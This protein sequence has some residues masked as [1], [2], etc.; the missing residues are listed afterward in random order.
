MWSDD[1]FR[2]AVAAETA[3]PPK[4]YDWAQWDWERISQYAL[5]NITPARVPGQV[6][7]YAKPPLGEGK[8]ACKRFTEIRLGQFG[9]EPENI[10]PAGKKR[11]APANTPETPSKPP[12]KTRVAGPRKPRARG[13]RKTVGTK[14]LPKSKEFVEP[15][16]SGS[17]DGHEEGDEDLSQQPKIWA[18]ESLRQ[19]RS[20]RDRIMAEAGR[21]RAEPSDSDAMDVLTLE[22]AESTDSER[23]DDSDVMDM[24]PRSANRNRSSSPSS[25]DGTQTPSRDNGTPTPSRRSDRSS[26]AESGGEEDRDLGSP[27]RI[28]PVVPQITSRTTTQMCRIHPPYPPGA[29]L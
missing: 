7:R 23:G 5:E 18:A 27:P 3:N 25:D 22:D 4:P 9:I 26:S 17:D 11:A 19:I 14:A 28:Q 1:Y 20:V 16:D 10:P 29:P 6:R 15:G 12:R 2:T 8:I 13:R 24:S 21:R